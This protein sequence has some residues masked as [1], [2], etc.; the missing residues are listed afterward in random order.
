MYTISIFVGY[1]PTIKLLKSKSIAQ[2]QLTATMNLPKMNLSKSVLKETIGD[3]MNQWQTMK[4][5]TLSAWMLGNVEET[6]VIQS[7]LQNMIHAGLTM[8]ASAYTSGTAQQPSTR[9]TT[10]STTST[11]SSNSQQKELFYDR[12]RYTI[13]CIDLID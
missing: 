3:S 4:N 1:A 9:F 2:P 12:F 7:K 6:E 13:N 8:N 10:R 11:S 5:S